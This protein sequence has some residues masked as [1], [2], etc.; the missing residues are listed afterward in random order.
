[1]AR[2]VYVCT[3]FGLLGAVSILIAYSFA[4][5]A[6]SDGAMKYPLECCHNYDCAPVIR[7]NRAPNT[8]IIVVETKFGTATVP[9]DM[10]PRES[11]DHRT[12]ACIRNGA[13]VC[14]FYPPSI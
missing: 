10:K 12:H 1:M 13:V 2:I 14:I 4:A 3:L 11:Q 8:P 5:R 9:P 7:A 6:H